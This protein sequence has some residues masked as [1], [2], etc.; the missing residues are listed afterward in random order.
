MIVLKEKVNFAR[1]GLTVIFDEDGRSH[2]V[3]NIVT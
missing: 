3:A 2:E 1:Q